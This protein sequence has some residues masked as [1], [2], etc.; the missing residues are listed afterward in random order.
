MR[1]AVPPGQQALDEQSLQRLG[2]LTRQLLAA[3]SEARPE[4]ERF[5]GISERAIPLP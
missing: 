4:Y 2:E 5:L 3:R 1:A